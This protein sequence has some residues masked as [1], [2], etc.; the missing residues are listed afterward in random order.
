MRVTI[1]KLTNLKNEKL[2]LLIFTGLLIAVHLHLAWQAGLAN[3]VVTTILFTSAI[4]FTHSKK[5]C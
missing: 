1:N 4:L 2:W 5:I 3:L